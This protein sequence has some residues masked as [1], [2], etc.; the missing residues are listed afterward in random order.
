MLYRRPLHARI[1]ET[2]DMLA[3]ELEYG[4]LLSHILTDDGK[5]L[6]QA[7][8]AEMGDW[9]SEAADL[10]QRQGMQPLAEVMRRIVERIT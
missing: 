2:R 1:T 9:A 4:A 3:E 10:P 8:I 5:E 6:L 7:I